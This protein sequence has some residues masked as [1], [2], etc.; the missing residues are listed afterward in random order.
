MNIFDHEVLEAV[1]DAY[2]FLGA[3]DLLDEGEAKMSAEG[4]TAAEKIIRER[5]ADE[6]DAENGGEND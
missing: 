6:I 5:F 3:C 1:R 4:V 2:D